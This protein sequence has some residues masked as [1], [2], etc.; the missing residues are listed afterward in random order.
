MSHSSP[1]AERVF[2]PAAS[3][4]GDLGEPAAPESRLSRSDAED[5]GRTIQSV[6]TA[7]AAMD[8]RHLDLIG[9]F[10]ARGGSGHFDSIKSTCHW[11]S[12]ACSMAAG[13]A[14]EHVRVARALRTLP[15]TRELL[16]QGRLT[17]SKVRELTRI[18]DQMDEHALCDLALEMTAAQLARTVRAYRTA[19]GT[20]IGHETRRALSWHETDDGMVRLSVRLP[21]EEAALLRTALDTA[22]AR[23]TPDTDRV[24]ALIDIA[25]GY[26]AT[27]HT[28]LAD[29]RH[30]V[31]V[32]VAAEQ[33]TDPTAGPTGVPAGPRPEEPQGVPAGTPGRAS[34]DGADCY[35]DDAGPGR[36]PIEPATAARL[37]CTSRLLGALIDR[38]GKVLALGRTTRR[39]T[40]AQRRALT[41]RDHGICQFPGCYATRHLDAHHILPWH[42]N[43]PTDLDNLIMLCR[44]HHTCCH[45]GGITIHPTSSPTAHWEFTLPDGTPV[46]APATWH[47]PDTAHHELIRQLQKWFDTGQYDEPRIFPPHA[48]AGFSLHECVRVLFDITKRTISRGTPVPG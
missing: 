2:P 19:P 40:R 32:H 48:G 25:S 16:G 30:L 7:Q 14:R 12:W 1:T 28:D 33:L 24:Q 23:A 4:S 9:E 31:I 35:L 18:A 22:I 29:D 11:L 43:G 13:T 5:L 27:D 47:A 6:A 26:L 42:H 17:Y 8:A 37:A 44:R 46:Q 38:H 20:R 34:A 41:I 39:A 10:D 21:A 3:R 15:R 36:T 45:E